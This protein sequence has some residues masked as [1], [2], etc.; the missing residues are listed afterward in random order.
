MKTITVKESEIQRKANT[1]DAK[2]M[3]TNASIPKSHYEK[4]INL[5]VSDDT[6]STKVN[7]QNFINAFNETKT[8]I[9]TKIKTELSKIPPPITGVG[10]KE[11][12]KADFNKMGYSEKLKLKAEK[13][14]LYQKLIK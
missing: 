8:E 12:T 6:E 4:F 3:L 9:E 2:D 1:L 11:V 5:L 10:D 13:P 7:V 14:E